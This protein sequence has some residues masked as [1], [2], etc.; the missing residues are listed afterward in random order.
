MSL[1]FLMDAPRGASPS[2]DAVSA[3]LS[4]RGVSLRAD[5]LARREWPASDEG[6]SRVPCKR[7][8]YNWLAT[9]GGYSNPS[10]GATGK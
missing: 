9:Q 2:P 4:V 3:M 7:E 6:Q 1:P 5:K 10:R 8:C